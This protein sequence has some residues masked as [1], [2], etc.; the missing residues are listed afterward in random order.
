M[1]ASIPTE[2]EENEPRTSSPI[3][4]N[5]IVGQGRFLQSPSP[6]LREQSPNR[7]VTLP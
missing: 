7:L 5:N 1:T 4:P 2:L 6:K 3:Q